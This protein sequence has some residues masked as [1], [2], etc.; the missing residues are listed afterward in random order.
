MK[1]TNPNAAQIE[2]LHAMAS[3]ETEEDLYELKQTISKFFA[4]KAQKELDKLWENG[5]LNQQKLDELR[6]Q[7][8]RTPYKS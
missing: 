7:H 6:K 4:R 3:I 8:L 2:L 5:T 1:L